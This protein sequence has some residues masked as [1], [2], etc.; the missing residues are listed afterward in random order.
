MDMNRRLNQSIV[1]PGHLI[2]QV[3]PTDKEKNIE[4]TV[5]LVRRVWRYFKEQSREF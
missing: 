1:F 4:V 5:R 3:E 2:G